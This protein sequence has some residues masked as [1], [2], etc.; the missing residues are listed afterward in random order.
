MS[1][2]VQVAGGLYDSHADQEHHCAGQTCFESTFEIT[3]ACNVVAVFLGMYLLNKSNA[4]RRY[5]PV[6]SD[7]DPGE[8]SSL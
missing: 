5:I 7:P 2:C 8:V 6:L 1:T 4:Q 3:T